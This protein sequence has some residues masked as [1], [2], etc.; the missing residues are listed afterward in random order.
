MNIGV[1]VKTQNC[2]D[3][4]I[5]NVLRYDRNVNIVDLVAT[6]KKKKGRGIKPTADWNCKI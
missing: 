5:I 3:N 1:P 4:N 2:V 6:V